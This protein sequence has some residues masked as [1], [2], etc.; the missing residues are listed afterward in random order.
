MERRE[1]RLRAM[2]RHEQ[3]RIAMASAEFSHHTPRGQKE[4][5]ARWREKEGH[6]KK[7]DG[8]RVLK[9]PLPRRHVRGTALRTRDALTERGPLVTTTTN[10]GPNLQFPRRVIHLEDL[11]LSTMRRRDRRLRA[12]LRREARKHRDGP[13]QVFA[14]HDTK[15]EGGQGWVDGGHEENYDDLRAL[16]PSLFSS[17]LPTPSSQDPC[18]QYYATDEDDEPPAAVRPARLQEVRPQE[19]I[20]ALARPLVD[21]VHMVQVINVPVSPEDCVVLSLKTTSRNKLWSISLSHPHP[22]ITPCVP[23]MIQ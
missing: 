16:Q 17:S 22:A 7:Y 23:Q 11:S 20:L 4:S 1:R 8:Q 15:S 9:P 21:L 5:S 14:Q 2:L 19:W 12:M 3:V 6:E 18:A 13:S 10:Q